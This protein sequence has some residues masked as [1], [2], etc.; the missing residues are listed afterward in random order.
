VTCRVNQAALVEVLTL[1]SYYEEPRARMIVGPYGCERHFRRHN[2]HLIMRPKPRGQASLTLHRDA[3]IPYPPGHKAIFKGQ[4]VKEELH[5]IVSAYK[6]RMEARR[7]E[8]SRAIH[9]EGIM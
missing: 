2:F 4:P 3:H 6:A 5:K 7:P 9:S 1:L 8:P